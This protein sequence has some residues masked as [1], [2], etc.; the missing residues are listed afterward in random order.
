[1]GYVRDDERNELGHSVEHGRNDRN[2]HDQRG[3]HH[4][5]V[6][7]PHAVGDRAR[8]VSLRLSTADRHAARL[9]R[10]RP[11]AR[12]LGEG[13]GA[14]DDHHRR[15]RAAGPGVS[16]AGEA[17][18]STGTAVSPSTLATPTTSPTG[19]GAAANGTVGTAPAAT[20]SLYPY[21]ID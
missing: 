4:G 6:R 21:L 18:S 19:N 10:D 15:A 20:P 11:V 3:P 7:D 12:D 13:S 16:A 2:A 1:M 14:G 17:L 5:D 9:D 8:D